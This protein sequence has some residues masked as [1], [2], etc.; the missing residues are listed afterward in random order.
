MPLRELAAYALLVT[1]GICEAYGYIEF[2]YETHPPE[3]PAILR[4]TITEEGTV[5][6]VYRQPNGEW[7]E[8][9][10]QGLRWG[11]PEEQEA[12]RIALNTR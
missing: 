10:E 12:A 5:M 7:P 6:V 11:S 3:P 2:T 8:L 9:P 4:A 1:P